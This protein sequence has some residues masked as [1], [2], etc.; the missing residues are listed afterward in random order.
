MA[1]EGDMRRRLAEACIEIVDVGR[2]WFAKGDAVR[3]EA[4]GFEQLFEA[5][6]PVVASFTSPRAWAYTLLGL[7][8]CPAGS[9]ETSRP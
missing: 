7:N 8:T 6:L 1:G 4:A 3:F 5:A 2:A 9:G